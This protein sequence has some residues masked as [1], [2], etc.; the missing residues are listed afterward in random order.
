MLSLVLDYCSWTCLRLEPMGGFSLDSVVV[1]DT[2]LGAVSGDRATLLLES[3]NVE[4]SSQL[5]NLY[6][7]TLD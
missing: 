7:S 1:P 2:M 5:I 3:L 6:G 4:I